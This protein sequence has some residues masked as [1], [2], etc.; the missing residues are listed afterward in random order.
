M[1]MR[2][3]GL[4]ETQLD[5]VM[6]Q[7]LAVHPFADARR[8]QQ[9]R[10]PLFEDAGAHP[11]LDVF[12]GMG[13]EDDVVDRPRA[14]AGGQASDRPALLRRWRLGCAWLRF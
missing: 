7:P 10:R 3:R 14:S 13:L 5:A 4:V 11:R 12:P 1:A 9:V 2:W 8:P 6:D